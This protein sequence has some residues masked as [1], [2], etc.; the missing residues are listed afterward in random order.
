M[1]DWQAV[2]AAH[3]GAVWRT[4][5]RVLN[6]HADAADCY[7]DTFAAAFRAGGAPV[8][9]WAAYLTTLATRKALDR[10]R[11][12]SRQRSRFAPLG[13]SDA[14]G[15]DGDQPLEQVA[16]G[17]LLD[18]LRRALAELPDA[19]AAV[20]WLSCIEGLPT[21]AV[22]AQLGASP[23]AVRVLLCRARAALAPT[24]AAPPARPRTPHE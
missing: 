1:T 10:L 15:P 23:G 11:A 13:E 24:F 22:A 14:P 18:R 19:Q 3:G 6:H 8:R 7:Q 5:Y 9:E 2:V 12:R 21:A 17:E 16:A 4:V 20:F